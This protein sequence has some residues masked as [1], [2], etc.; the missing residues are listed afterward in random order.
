MSNMGT[1]YVIENQNGEAEAIGFES[2]FDAREAAREI[3][4]KMAAFSSVGELRA[5]YDEDSWVQRY[6]DEELAEDMV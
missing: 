4:G 6:S 1:I 3:D 2:R 5:A